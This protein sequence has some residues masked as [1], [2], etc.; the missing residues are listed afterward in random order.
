MAQLRLILLLQVIQKIGL[1][2]SLYDVLWTSEG[3]IGH[4]TG[5]VNVNGKFGLPCAS[6]QLILTN[7]TVEFRMIV[8]RPFK[9][10]VLLGKIRSSTVNGINVRTE[11]F[12]EIFIPYSELPQGAE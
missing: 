12:D 2:I 5:L 4:G 7:G 9:G 11:F 6:W 8:F 1:C 3:L 10:E